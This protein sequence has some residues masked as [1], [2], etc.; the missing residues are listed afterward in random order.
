MKRILSLS[1]LVVFATT[2]LFIGCS[3]KPTEVKFGYVPYTVAFPAFVA[4]EKGFFE[5]HGLKVDLVEFKGANDA[6][7]AVI[8]GQVVGQAG[9]GASTPLIIEAKKRNELVITWA[10]GETKD[11]STTFLLVKKGSSI[12][13]LQQLAGKKIGVHPGPTQVIN[14]RL[15]LKDVG[16]EG[17]AQIV[18]L[19]QNSLL[20]ALASG[21]L[22]AVF[23]TEP[24]GTVALEQGIAQVLEAN[25]R[26]DHIM[27]PF[28]GGYGILSKSFVEKNPRAAKELIAAIDQAIDYIRSNETEAKALLPKYTPM[29][30]SL[31]S[32]SKLYEWWKLSEIALTNQQA[33]ADL[34]YHNQILPESV[35]VK[36]MLYK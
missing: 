21:A 32:K 7:N 4:K 25:P 2:V 30:A 26:C 15:I 17:K 12:T 23:V 22:D 3:G 11:K 18:E 34:L 13:S 27:C 1:V 10:M 31:S 20:P 14:V 9:I 16:M 5:K 29:D 19:D 24:Q 33:F 35:S 28:P 6:I 36:D 8:A